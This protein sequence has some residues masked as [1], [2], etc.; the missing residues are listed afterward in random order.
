MADDLIDCRC[1]LTP[2]SHRVLMAK[3]QATGADMS[4]QIREVMDKWAVD[5]L[6]ALTVMHRILEG[7]GCGRETKGSQA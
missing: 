4:A 1:R 7:E 5:E 3:A 6:H 2:R